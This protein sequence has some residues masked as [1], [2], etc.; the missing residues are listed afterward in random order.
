M[1]GFEVDDKNQ[2]IAN[3]KTPF[4]VMSNVRG[5]KAQHTHTDQHSATFS[6]GP[7]ISERQFDTFTRW[8]DTEIDSSGSSFCTQNIVFFFFLLLF[9]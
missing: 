3:R 9:I 4:D 7:V 1:F 8:D 5:C 2:D 6:F